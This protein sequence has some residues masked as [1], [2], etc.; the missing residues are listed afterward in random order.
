[1]PVCV[2]STHVLS[3]YLCAHIYRY[4]HTYT[5]NHIYIYVCVC[6]RVCVCVL[7]MCCLFTYVHTYIDTY[8]H[9][10]TLHYITLRYVTLHYIHT[11]IHICIYIYMCVCVFACVFYTCVACILMCIHI[12][13]HKYIYIDTY[14]YMYVCICVYICVCVCVL[15]CIFYI[16]FIY[17]W[18][19][20]GA[21]KEGLM[22]CRVSL[23][24]KSTGQGS[25][26]LQ[27][28]ITMEIMGNL[29]KSPLA[30]D[31]MFLNAIDILHIC[32]Y[33]DTWYRYRYRCRY[34]HCHLPLADWNSG[35]SMA[36]F[37]FEYQRLCLGF[38]SI[39]HWTTGPLERHGWSIGPATQRTWPP[40]WCL[41]RILLAIKPLSTSS[42][43]YGSYGPW[44][45]DGWTP[46]VT[47]NCGLKDG[48]S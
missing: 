25:F 34:A 7:H 32:I 16:C 9:Y 10:I 18:T 46:R 26:S 48:C 2:C 3:V 12:L 38:N 40:C 19:H 29:Q 11:Y 13:M 23:G 41:G 21:P 14:T 17:L 4:I 36:M 5:Y 33:R 24:L 28:N 1:M 27:S 47:R 31:T 15:M 39:H 6:L 22:S 43:K 20:L 35:F 45:C 37:E 8:I 42:V 30:N 44:K